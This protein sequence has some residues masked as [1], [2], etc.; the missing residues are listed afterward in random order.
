MN[1]A[2]SLSERIMCGI[3]HIHAILRAIVS[4]CEFASTKHSSGITLSN[5]LVG[6][7]FML[8]VNHNG[9]CH[10]SLL[11]NSW[12]TEIPLVT[13]SAAWV[14][15]PWTKFPSVWIDSRVN[16]FHPVSQQMFSNYCLVFSYPAQG[17]ITVGPSNYFIKSSH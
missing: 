15:V 16:S 1:Y 3:L 12:W 6:H 14:M 8:C 9:P 11:L 7:F 5:S 17:D 2:V 4:F 10:Q 13:K